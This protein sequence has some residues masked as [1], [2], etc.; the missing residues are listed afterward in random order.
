[1]ILFNLKYH[2]TTSL[3][4]FIKPK[5]YLI[6]YPGH[7]ITTSETLTKNKRGTGKGNVD[8]EYWITLSLSRGS[9]KI[10]IH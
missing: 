3:A 2:L 9:S 1:M 4:I 7:F 10:I 5:N 8:Y 6:L